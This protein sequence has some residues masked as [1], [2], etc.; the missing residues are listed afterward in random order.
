MSDLLEEI[1]AQTSLPSPP[2]L[3]SQLT[4]MLQKDN[5]SSRE[6]AKIAET[7]QAFT[8]RILKLVNSP[9]YGF[10]RQITSVKD[11]ITMLGLQVVNQLLLTTSVLESLKVDHKLININQFWLHSF[12]VGVLA[13][14][15]LY[16]ESDDLRSSAFMCGI[17]HDIGR[18]LFVNLD[19]EKYLAFYNKGESVID[20][21]KEKKWFGMN[22][23]EVGSALGRKWNFPDAF[24]D[25]IENH[26]HPQKSKDN[27][28]LLSAVNIGDIISHAMNVGNSGSAY[29]TDFTPETW[30]ILNISYDKLKEIIIKA[31]DEIEQTKTFLE[32]FHEK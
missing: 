19:S 26:H 9:F 13:K 29:V 16:N 2:A 11:S 1:E 21:D 14:H 25:V 30:E 10:S 28:K 23:Q 5:V 7:D 12:A 18:L 31:L 8:A 22:H 15:I 24:I 4:S 20:L 6:L 27:K 17:L 3:I 32:G